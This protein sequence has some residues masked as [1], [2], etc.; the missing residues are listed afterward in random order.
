[1]KVAVI[2]GG[3]AGLCAAIALER[4]GV[5]VEIFERNAAIREIGAGLSLWPNATYALRGLGLLEACVRVSSRVCKIRL[6]DPGGREWA[7]AAVTGPATPALG[8]DRPALLAVLLAAVEPRRIHVGQDCAGVSLAPDQRPRV[9]FEGGRTAAFDAVIGADGLGSVVRRFVTGRAERP[10]YRGYLIWRGVAPAP[11]SFY[12]A[13]DITEAWGQG[14]RFGVMPIGEGKVCWYATRNQPDTAAPASKAGLL[15]HFRSWHPAIS[16]LIA[17]TPEPVI[18]RTPALD[19]PAAWSWARGP[20]VLVGDAAHPMTPNLGQGTCQAIE[21]ALILSRFLARGVP[22]EAA[23]RGFEKA[24]RVRA[25]AIV[26]GARWVGGFAQSEGWA[27]RLMLRRL[28]G[29]VLSGAVDRIFRAP[30]G[31]RA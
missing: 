27:A 7:S 18:V 1:L 26:L 11:A 5:D 20:V 13:G 15:E 4:V 8:L 19:R 25:A 10:V 28:P 16:E 24:R 21:D 2:G 30:H 3:I 17:A 22:V 6:R 9:H 23:F 29:F 12:A 14:E 31:Y